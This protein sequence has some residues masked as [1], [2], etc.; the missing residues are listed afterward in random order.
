MPLNHTQ[1]N[2]FMISSINLSLERYN[3]LKNMRLQGS[4]KVK[5]IFLKKKGLDPFII[6]TITR[7]H[8]S[9]LSVGGNVFQNTNDLN[10]SL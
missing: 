1:V 2:L 3:P 10:D 7:G 5:I 9:V 8:P 6:T 4:L